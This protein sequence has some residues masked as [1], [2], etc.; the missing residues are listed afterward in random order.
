MENTVKKRNKYSNMQENQRRIYLHF[1]VSDAA[2]N[3]AALI[4]CFS[5]KK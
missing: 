5:R 1:S 3:P 4:L 2:V